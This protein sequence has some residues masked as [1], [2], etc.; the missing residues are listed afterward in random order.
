MLVDFDC[1]NE[2]RTVISHWDST[3]R[4]LPPLTWQWLSNVKVGIKPQLSDRLPPRLRYLTCS[5]FSV[6]VTSGGWYLLGSAGVLTN[7]AG[8]SG[9][10]GGGSLSI[11]WLYISCGG[12]WLSGPATL[13]RS[14]GSCYSGL[15]LDAG[16][17][18]S[19][20]TSPPSLA[21]LA[22]IVLVISILL[23]FILL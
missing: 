16:N 21:C 17:A 2:D 22:V 5:T 10:G 1:D 15:S 7:M 23:S 11:C 8:G 9:G 4:R 6:C 20:T 13:L 18:A 3:E 14:P 12:W 19:S